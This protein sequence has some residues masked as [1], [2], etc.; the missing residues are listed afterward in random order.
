LAR[1]FIGYRCADAGSARH[2]FLEHLVAAHGDVGDRLGDRRL[3]AYVYVVRRIDGHAA[4]GRTRIDGDLGATA[5]GD[6]H[7]AMAGN[8]Q[9]AVIAHQG[10]G[11]RDRAT[12]GHGGLV[13]RQHC[14]DLAFGIGH[15]DRGRV[16][17]L[18]L[19][20]GGVRHFGLADT[21]RD[22]ARVLEHVVTLRRCGVDLAGLTRLEEHGVVIAQGNGQVLV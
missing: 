17:E 19:L 3:A 20:E 22:G 6:G 2:Q 12:F 18:Q 15:A 13:H 16:A 5:Q 9:V 4:G 7:T 1:R 10:H 21:H 11:V 8:R 14:S